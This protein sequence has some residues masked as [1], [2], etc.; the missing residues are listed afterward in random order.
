MRQTRLIH[1]LVGGLLVV[2]VGLAG[3]LLA[4]PL[5]IGDPLTVVC[6]GAPTM[7][8]GAQDDRPAGLQIQVGGAGDFLLL[9]MCICIHARSKM[10]R[11]KD[12]AGNVGRSDARAHAGV[13][14]RKNAYLFSPTGGAE[15]RSPAPGGTGWSRTASD[16]S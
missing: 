10:E 9:D 2:S 11:T 12:R 6:P 3:A 5:L 4:I 8:A 1:F 13:G 15:P 16:S 14:Q 7:L